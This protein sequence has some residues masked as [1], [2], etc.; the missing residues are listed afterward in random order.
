MVSTVKEKTKNFPCYLC[1]QLFDPNKTSSQRK[2]QNRY[3]ISTTKAGKK[4]SDFFK[5]STFLFPLKPS[6]KG[7]ISIVDAQNPGFTRTLRISEICL[8]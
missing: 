6:S 3:S 5:V 2:T 8:I 7:L 1:L 4:P